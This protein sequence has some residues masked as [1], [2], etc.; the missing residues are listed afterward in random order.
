[1]QSDAERLK[2]I[3]QADDAHWKEDVTIQASEQSRLAAAQAAEIHAKAMAQTDYDLRLELAR[4]ANDLR[5]AQMDAQINLSNDQI[6]AAQNALNVWAAANPGAVT[7]REQALF[8]AQA[9]WIRDTSQKLSDWVDDVNNRLI[10]SGA[11]GSVETVAQADRADQSADAY[12]TF[13]EAQNVHWLD[14]SADLETAS[15]DRRQAQSLA[16]TNYQVNPTPSTLAGGPTFDSS[17]HATSQSYEDLVSTASQNRQAAATIDEQAIYTGLVQ[18]ATLTWLTGTTAEDGIRRMA[19]MQ[20]WLQHGRQT[21][22]ASRDYQ[23]GLAPYSGPDPLPTLTL[24]A[25]DAAFT[26][27]DDALE[28]SHVTNDVDWRIL[29]ATHD[30]TFAAALA[31]AERDSLINAAIRDDVYARAIADADRKIQ[32]WTHTVDVWYMGEVNDAEKIRQ[33][34]LALTQANWRDALYQANVDAWT[35]VDNDLA[36]PWTDFRKDEAM[37]QQSAW[38]DRRGSVIGTT[39]DPAGG[40]RLK[41]L[42][43]Q[44]HVIQAEHDYQSTLIA[45]Y[46]TM[47]TGPTGAIEARHVQACADSASRLN[48]ATVYAQD[49]YQFAVDSVA[50]ESTWQIDSTFEEWEAAGGPAASG[51]QAAID[52]DY[53]AAIEGLQDGMALPV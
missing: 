24:V 52:A 41:W 26:A 8:D 11:T 47:I 18:P 43:M 30:Q 27:A 3:A 31:A 13:A 5:R 51:S 49:F 44:S 35:A 6:A 40:Y 45:A 29:T 9:D 12:A 36:L 1:M 53:I 10:S 48:S 7:D 42:E 34:S 2:A 17:L 28:L 19:V 22:E 23:A 21:F 39:P 16:C 4:E 14:Y 25:R 46:D 20:S 33:Q 37:E 15:S 32:T 50:A 38:L